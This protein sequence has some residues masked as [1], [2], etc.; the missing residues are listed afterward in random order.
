MIK[1]TNF[2]DPSSYPPNE[3]EEEDEGGKPTPWQLPEYPHLIRDL[4]VDMVVSRLGYFKFKGS[5][6]PISM[7]T[8]SF[9]SL[10]GRR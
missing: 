6:D 2:E 7:A 5:P 4:Q 9:S 1:P 10:M 3:I 8:V